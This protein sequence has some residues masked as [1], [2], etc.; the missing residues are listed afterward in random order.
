MIA[1]PKPAT[2][3]E[4]EALIREARSRQLRRRLLGAA[5]VAIGAAIA[6]A[7]YAFVTGGSVRNVA[8][9][10]ANGG[11]ATGPTCR[12]SQ[13][14]ATIGFQGATQTLVGGAEVKNISDHACSLPLGWPQVTLTSSGKALSVVQRRPT[15]SVGSSEPVA[16]VLA[17]GGRAGVE[18]QWAN[19][20]GSPH[21]P[22]NHGGYTLTPL[23][24]VFTL[25]FGT[26][27]VVTAASTGAPPC[28]A[29][30]RPS[31]LIADRAR[32]AQ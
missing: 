24:E 28:L 16:R 15:S 9:P 20:C 26:G 27:P 23:K 3:E 29:P 19:W 5:G 2:H 18:M 31:V 22:V 11:R 7:A 10:P 25:R 6:L 8:Q 14:A 17:P 30:S 12:A 1:P 32:T 4:L 21:Q 13:L